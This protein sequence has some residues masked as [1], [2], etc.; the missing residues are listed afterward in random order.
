LSF[1]CLY[2]SQYIADLPAANGGPAWNPNPAAR[3]V[4]F[5]LLAIVLAV[6]SVVLLV[7]TLRTL[8]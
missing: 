1:A 4:V 6:G 3:V 2:H 5:L 8:S 7:R